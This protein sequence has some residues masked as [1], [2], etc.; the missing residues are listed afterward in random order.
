MPL[1]RKHHLMRLP[2]MI[3][4]ELAKYGYRL[5]NKD[6]PN[7]LQSI[8][9]ANGGIKLHRYPI[10]SRNTPNIQA[11][12]VHQFNISYLCKGISTHSGLPIQIKQCTTLHGFVNP[13]DTYRILSIHTVRE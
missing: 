6:Y 12:Q 13:F 8:T 1:Y 11:H 3:E 5:T 2:D 4:M 9:N 7:S 10:Q